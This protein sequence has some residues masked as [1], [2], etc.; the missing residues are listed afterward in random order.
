MHISVN[1]SVP[2]LIQIN[3]GT[4]HIDLQL[5]MRHGFLIIPTSAAIQT[6]CQIHDY[7]DLVG[8][9]RLDRA[10]VSTRKPHSSVRIAYI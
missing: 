10:C 1:L 5:H 9:R 3:G 8:Q 2:E 7:R 6:Q 4:C